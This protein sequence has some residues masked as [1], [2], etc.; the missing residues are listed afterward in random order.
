MHDAIL[1]IRQSI[2]E[3]NHIENGLAFAK[4]SLVFGNEYAVDMDA[5]AIVKS[6]N[7]CL[8]MDKL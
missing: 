5:N 3:V 6:F 4:C 2:E 7:D 1:L 8:A